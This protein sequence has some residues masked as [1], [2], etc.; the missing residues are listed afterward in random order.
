[1]EGVRRRPSLRYPLCRGKKRF[2]RNQRPFLTPATSQF[3]EWFTERGGIETGADKEMTIPPPGP[4]RRKGLHHGTAFFLPLPWVGTGK[5]PVT[6]EFRIRKIFC[7]EKKS[8]EGKAQSLS[9]PFLRRGGG[10]FWVNALISPLCCLDKKA[11]KE[12]KVKVTGQ[13]HN[14]NPWKK[15]EANATKGSSQRRRDM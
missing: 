13:T 9:A 1:M 5:I 3:F 7:S 6:G 4:P 10:A 2:K 11:Q 15:G 14:R 8:A 12:V